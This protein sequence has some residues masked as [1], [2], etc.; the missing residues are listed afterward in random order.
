LGYPDS[1]PLV[2]FSSDIQPQLEQL[3]AIEEAVNL[4]A[5]EEE[6]LETM[7]VDV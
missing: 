7:V 4:A 2:A 3:V 5:L 6:D 1:L